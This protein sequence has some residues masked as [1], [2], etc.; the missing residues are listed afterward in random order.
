MSLVDVDGLSLRYGARTVLSRVSLSIAPGEI[1]TIVG[2]NGS[3]K[4]SLLRAIIGAV[5]PFQGRVTRGAGVTL[6]YVPQKL[7]IDETLPMTV[8]RFLRLPGGASEAEIDQALAQAGV[9]DLSGSQLAQLSGG[10]FQRVMLARALIGKPDL[11]LL[12]EAT[13]GLD[14]RGSA[15]FYQQIEQVRRDTGCAVLMISHELHVV[16]SASDRVICLNGH[17]CCEGTPAVV[18]SAPEYRA[19]FGT[20]TGGALA[21]YRHEHDHEH[22]HHDG[23][24]HGQATEDRTEAAE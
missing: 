18:A 13:Q 19:L 20:G 11:L 10:Q 7:H 21:L 23:C 15:S 2:P 5:K 24:A 4:T 6:G 1:V 8:A 17:V 14:Q 3:G 22:D 16:M 12:D 9:R